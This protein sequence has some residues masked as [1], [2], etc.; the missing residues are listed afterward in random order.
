MIPDLYRCP[1]SDR[2]HLL[3]EP[4]G[5]AVFAVSQ[6]H[7]QQVDAEKQKRAVLYDDI[8]SEDD[9]RGPQPSGMIAHPHRKA[10]PAEPFDRMAHHKPRVNRRA[11]RHQR[12]VD[13]G[14]EKLQPQLW[15]DARASSAAP[16]ASQGTLRLSSSVLSK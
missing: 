13:K 8:D 2:T 11:V 14:A 3:R 10:V 4:S 5:P 7:R 15:Q 6:Q 12:M 1:V 16:S 9:K